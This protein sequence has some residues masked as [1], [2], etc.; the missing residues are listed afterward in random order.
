MRSGLPSTILSAQEETVRRPTLQVLLGST[1]VDVSA[2]VRSVEVREPSDGASTAAV[3]LASPNGKFD[4]FGSCPDSCLVFYNNDIKI[5][6]GYDGTT[7]DIFTGYITQAPGIDY[8]PG[9]EEIASINCVDKSKPFLD[10]K[11]T[12]HRYEDVSRNQIL[13]GSCGVFTFYGGLSESEVSLSDSAM[14]ELIESPVQFSDK[15]IWDIGKMVAESKLRRIGFDYSGTLR[16]W[17]MTYSTA[18]LATFGAEKVISVTTSWDDSDCFSTAIV[19]GGV[20]GTYATLSDE[21]EIG[22]Q[23]V[24]QTG[25]NWR[26]W[27]YHTYTPVA[28]TTI[29]F[30]Y[31]GS[32]VDL[33]DSYIMKATPTKTQIHL[34]CKKWQR[35]G[36]RTKKDIK[37]QVYLYGRVIQYHDI[38]PIGEYTD[39]SLEDAYPEKYEYENPVVLSSDDAVE[40]AQ[41]LVTLAKW[42]RGKVRATVA[43]DFRVERGD[44]VS[45]WSPRHNKYLL[46]YVDSISRRWEVGGDETMSID[47]FYVGGVSS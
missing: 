20:L 5:K 13:A 14:D 10:K 22:N 9:G 38:I 41:S 4:I 24:F 18:P 16:T 27:I 35:L 44:T 7:V 34:D 15:T 45:I 37:G 8:T 42:K 29:R 6:C 33:S 31:E 46:V 23:Y 21:R 11:I 2:Y 3:E 1:L 36:W 28:T 43:N 25:G 39:P 12:T 47:G 19:K 32:G 30:E 17:E 26:G 40:L